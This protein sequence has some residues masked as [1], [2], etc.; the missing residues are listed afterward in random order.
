MLVPKYVCMCVGFREYTRLFARRTHTHTHT[1]RS[2]QTRL[3][4]AGYIVAIMWKD[5]I[6][7]ATNADFTLAN[8][9]RIS[10]F[11]RR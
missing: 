11:E 9:T 1:Y 6:D 8:V 2:A 3:L 5:E 10:F 7:S 4:A